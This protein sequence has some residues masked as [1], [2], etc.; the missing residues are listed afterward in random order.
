MRIL[1]EFCVREVMDEVVAIP[2]GEAAKK[3][4]GIISL[5]P[6]SRFLFEKLQQEQTVQSLVDA[7]LEEYEVDPQTAQQDVESFLD[8]LRQRQLLVEEA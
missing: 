5:D 1:N 3:F 8:Q 2:T 7:V 6:V 4:Y